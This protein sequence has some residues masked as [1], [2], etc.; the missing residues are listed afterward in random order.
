MS[1][2]SSWRGVAA[3]ALGFDC[4]VFKVWTSA[5]KG[6]SSKLGAVYSAG[7][8]RAVDWSGNISWDSTIDLGNTYL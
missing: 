6:S 5:V 7:L 1:T 2:G 3:E 4:G 8:T